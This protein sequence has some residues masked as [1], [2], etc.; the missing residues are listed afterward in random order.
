MEHIQITFQT[1]VVA[2][3]ISI[4]VLAMQ[5]GFVYEIT[6]KR[7]SDQDSSCRVKTKML[8]VRVK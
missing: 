6:L 8:I 7:K 2:M 1:C 3:T 4:L 5:L